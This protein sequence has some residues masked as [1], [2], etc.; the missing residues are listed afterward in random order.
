MNTSEGV[1]AGEVA[2]ADVDVGGERTTAMTAHPFRALVPG[3]GRVLARDQG[4]GQGLGQDRDLRLA[5][6][7]STAS[8]SAHVRGIGIGIG[9][10]DTKARA[11]RR[12]GVT[13]RNSNNKELVESTALILMARARQRRRRL[14]L[15]ALA[16]SRA[17]LWGGDGA[18]LRVDTHLASLILRASG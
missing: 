11:A 4:R 5:R 2:G 10:M 9:I 1:H 16:A 12:A 3:P 17:A 8:A 18:V 13:G 14:L 15:V 7:T 6:G